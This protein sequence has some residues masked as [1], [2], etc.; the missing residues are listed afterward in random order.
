MWWSESFLGRSFRLLI[1]DGIP[2]NW[3]DFW[4]KSSGKFTNAQRATR[5]LEELGPTYVKFGQALA[6]RP[7]VIPTALGGFV[8]NLTR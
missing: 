4:L 6:S 5:A 8:S 7:D 1:F 3:E 2:D